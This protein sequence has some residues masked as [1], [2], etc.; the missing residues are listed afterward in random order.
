VT[1]PNILYLHSHDT[2]RA[3]QPYGYAVPTPNL[4]KLAE[5]GV[6]FRQAFNVA[7]TCSPSRAG[8][9]TGMCAHSSGMIGLAHRGFSLFDY[10]RHIVHALRTAGYRSTLIG[11]QHVAAKPE[12]IG[13]D[14]V[15]G[16]ASNHVCDVTPAAVEWL[17]GEPEGPFFLAVGF[18]ET[19]REFI[20]AGP[21][22]DERYTRS[23]THLPDTPE[24]R[25]DM[26]E[27]A[28]TAR[29]LDGGMGAVLDALDG[30]GL[31]ENTLVICTTDHGMAFPGA[32]CNL[33]D[34]GIGVML[35][36]RGPGG[37]TGGRVCDA[38]VSH[39]DLFPT[40]CDLTGIEPPA[41]LQGTS[42]MPLIRGETD[43]VNARIYADVT[44]HATYEPLR[45]VRT[46]RWKY[47][48]RFQARQGPVLSNCDPSISKD[49]WMAHG[50]TETPPEMEQL[51]DLVYDPN[52]VRNLVDA[53]EYTSV[54]ERLRADLAAWMERTDDPLLDGDVPPPPGAV[55]NHPDAIS[56]REPLLGG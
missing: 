34:H 5:E 33:T 11:V 41:W 39:M 27:F 28:A 36:M 32:K 30:A 46:K 13:Y 7:P 31:A 38:M 9:V 1:H 43:E 29:V 15:V 26:A 24:T 16:V 55:Y 19:H 6:L 50:W 54:L 22:E 8:L 25:R 45:C 23:P 35:M 20:A 53:P 3:I 37:F 18:Q 40:L 42:I 10:D 47:I 14:E 56:H 4:Q 12:T 49:I 51:Y 2:G 44:Y 52:E 21:D 48:R 17:R